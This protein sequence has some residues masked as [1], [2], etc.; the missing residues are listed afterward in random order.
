MRVD[1]GHTATRVE[2]CLVHSGS[3]VRV[4][5]DHLSDV[6]GED[7]ADD[8]T[9]EKS[10]SRWALSSRF[11]LWGDNT[12]ALRGCLLSPHKPEDLASPLSGSLKLMTL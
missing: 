7:N 6:S 10:W 1:G 2:R 11:S 12:E 8:A 4:E 3:S 5:D 9:I